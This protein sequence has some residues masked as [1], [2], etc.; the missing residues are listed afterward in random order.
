[1]NEVRDIIAGVVGAADVDAIIADN[2]DIKLLKTK[3]H[4]WLSRAGGKAVVCFE[5]NGE[6]YQTNL[7]GTHQAAN[8]IYALEIIARLRSGGANIS[9]ERVEAA[10]MNVPLDGR[11]ETICPR[12]FI[13]FDTVQSEAD[14]RN[15]IGTVDDYF[16]RQMKRQMRT[17]DNLHPDS[18]KRLI[19]ADVFFAPLIKIKQNVQIIF[20]S[21]ALQ[22]AYLAAYNGVV[23]TSVMPIDRAVA[24]AKKTF[25]DHKIFIIGGRELYNKVKNS[26]R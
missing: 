4:S 20:T 17:A 19:I 22:A 21:D 26:L 15:F 14:M 13:V 5:H 18:F 12:P 7:R 3:I 11:F 24:Y 16:G 8:C 10:L 2:A 25:P 1:M 9:R 23:K 6:Q